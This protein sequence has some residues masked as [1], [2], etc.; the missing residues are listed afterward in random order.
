MVLN[1]THGETVECEATVRNTGTVSLNLE[2]RFI[3]VFGSQIIGRSEVYVTLSPNEE[4][5]G[6]S[7]FTLGTSMVEGQYRV[8]VLLKDVDTGEPYDSSEDYFTLTSSSLPTAIIGKIVPYGG[9]QVGV[10]IDNT[11][12][13]DSYFYIAASVGLDA[14]GSGCGCGFT[15]GVL[16][17]LPVSEWYI[18]PLGRY[19]S[20]TFTLTNIPEGGTVNSY[21]IVKV[22]REKIDPLINDT[23]VD[24]GYVQY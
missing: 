13:I 11:S 7:F 15:G 10:T 4:T 6:F 8:R 21:L 2:M 14:S 23:C 12:N 19:S 22:Y 9:G 18:A 20:N 24:G 1:K 16:Y 17:D 5:S 3:L